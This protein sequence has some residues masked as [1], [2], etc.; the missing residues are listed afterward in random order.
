M[1][2]TSLPPPHRPQ[3]PPNHTTT[4]ATTSPPDLLCTSPPPSNCTGWLFLYQFLYHMLH[5]FSTLAPPLVLHKRKLSTRVTQ[6]RNGQTH[7][8]TRDVSL[9]SST[10]SCLARRPACR[11]RCAFDGGSSARAR[12]G[13]GRGADRPPRPPAL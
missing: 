7:T 9:E 2:T 6:P 1:W 13:S 3:S 5:L 11:R 4:R 12:P 10:A 8:H